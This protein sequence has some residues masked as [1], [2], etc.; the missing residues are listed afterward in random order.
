MSVRYARRLGR[1]SWLSVP[2]PAVL[3]AVWLLW[4]LALLWTAGWLSLRALQAGCLILA[5]TARLTAS[6]AAVAAALAQ[7]WLERRA[8]RR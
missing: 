7:T 1:H 4:P 8:R 3:L 6:G 2:L 5:A